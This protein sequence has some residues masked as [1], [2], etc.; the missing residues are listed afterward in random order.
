MRHILSHYDIKDSKVQAWAI[1]VASVKN[2]QR[3]VTQLTI[4]LM[5]FFLYNIC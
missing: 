3:I 1:Y 2:Y 4:K 5:V